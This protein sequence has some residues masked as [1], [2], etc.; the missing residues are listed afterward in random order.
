MPS[1]HPSRPGSPVKGE[2]AEGSTSQPTLPARTVVTILQVFAQGVVTSLHALAVLAIV[3][4]T[5]QILLNG[6]RSLAS[7]SPAGGHFRTVY[8]QY[9]RWLVAALTFQLAADI[10][11]TVIT[12]VLD[13][14]EIGHLAAIAAIRT[15]LN[16]F[17][18][19]DIEHME[20]YRP[21]EAPDPPVTPAPL[22]RR[23]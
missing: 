16:F 3:V 20:R 13:W 5:L 8:L 12:P 18:E 2:G 21:P 15:F 23:P 17:L 6:F 14:N 10:V 1:P 9:A 19:R 4:G 11:Q 7:Q 22:T